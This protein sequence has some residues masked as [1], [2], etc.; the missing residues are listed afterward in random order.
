MTHAEGTTTY[1]L[2]LLGHR[3]KLP[4]L[5]DQHAK[6]TYAVVWNVWE[7]PA[8]CLAYIARLL[9]GNKAHILGLIT[10]N[11]YVYPT[12][13]P[14]TGLPERSHATVAISQTR[15]G[16]GGGIYLAN[17][18]G[19]MVRIGDYLGN[20]ESAVR[21]GRTS[22]GA[23]TWTK[24][25]RSVY[26]TFMAMIFLHYQIVHPKDGEAAVRA[27]ADSGFPSSLDMSLTT[28]AEPVSVFSNFQR[29]PVPDAIEAALYAIDRKTDPSGFEAFAHEEFEQIDLDRLRTLSTAG[30]MTL[31]RIARNDSFYINFDRSGMTERDVRFILDAEMHLNRV[32]RVLDLL[33]CGLSP[34]TS[35]PSNQ[36]CSALAM[37]D[38][39][40][41]GSL[42]EKV[43]RRATEQNA[44][45][46]PGTITCKP[47]GAWDIRTRLA[48]TC[49]SLNLIA[50][51]EY[52]ID[53]DEESG[54]ITIDFIPP[55]A[56]GLSARYFDERDG[57]WRDLSDEG[58]AGIAREIAARMAI[59]IAAAGFSSG[60]MVRRCVVNQ[61]AFAGADRVC[62]SFDRAEYLGSIAPLAESLERE[63]LDEGLAARELARFEIDG[64][65]LDTAI[66]PRK[67]VPREDARALPQDLRDMLL[68]DRAY[69][70]EIME[71]PG[72]TMLER[73]E[74]LRASAAADPTSTARELTG[75]IEEL[76]ASCVAAEL[77]AEGPVSSQYCENY[78]ARMALG[79]H[80][81][82]HALRINRVPDALYNAQHALA[83]MYFNAGDFDRALAEAR[84]LLDMAS[85]SSSAHF[86]VINALAHLE[87]WE[88]LIDVAKHGM[89]CVSQ[90]DAIAYYFYRIAFAYWSIGDLETAL[91]CYRMI[92]RGENVDQNAQ[93]EMGQLMNQMGLSE[94]PTLA[95]ARAAVSRVGIEP[96]PS[97]AF[98][99]FLADAAVRLTD[100][101]FF[102]L[103]ARC[104]HE[105]WR[106]MGRDELNVI[107]KSLLP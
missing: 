70:L 33:G 27:A 95:S 48:Q 65:A 64:R 87:R 24:Q 6:D 104:I 25:H 105:M 36:T 31:A 43:L 35:S 50:R 26:R 29:M 54:C 15:E 44:W 38:L 66:D 2:P 89:A 107:M 39:A 61:R 18:A 8:E 47:G 14:I 83:N 90:R 51:L 13:R 49:E 4:V 81:E 23:V 32:S 57:S 20:V 22:G 76:Q 1:K 53:H 55:A 12:T 45:G 94:P 11:G 21:E 69:D 10:T 9:P 75:I 96:P 72:D 86:A 40:S 7:Q 79:L 103:A 84:K 80:A 68:A 98:M 71:H 102:F 59:V 16:K 88:E 100:E 62:R 46:R 78:T 73:V 28:L 5:P 63:P 30:S 56:G 60:A 106:V 17:G 92:P 3:E 58:R 99:D 41:I 19:R 97:D 67:V 52:G 82:N 85:T 37:R 91:A 77:M 42:V 74:S 101:G 93:E 34:L